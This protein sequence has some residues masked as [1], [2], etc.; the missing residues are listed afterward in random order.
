MTQRASIAALLHEIDRRSPAGFA[1]AMHI[2]FTRPTYL[3]QTYAKRWMDYYSAMGMVVHDPLVHWGLQ[4]VGRIRWSDLEA[5]DSHGV[6]EA[7]KDFGLMNGASIAVLIAG[8]R[9][10]SGFARADREY[11]DPEMAD[12]E[13]I[14]AELHLATAGLGDL[15]ESDQ[16][17][18]TELSIK[19]TH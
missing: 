7:A 19:L 14:L 9:S 10:I 13:D 5:I 15:S 2:R 8:S 3:F 16:S 12:L 17:A 4:N 18:L 6:L 11:T 1:V